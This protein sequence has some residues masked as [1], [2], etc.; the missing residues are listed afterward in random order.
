MYV[1]QNT[2]RAACCPV[3]P[4]SCLAVAR[5]GA[6]QMAQAVQQKKTVLKSVKEIPGP[7]TFPVIG[8]LPS[9]V[10]AGMC[11]YELGLFISCY[12][13]ISNRLYL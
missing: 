11:E 10:I 3:L 7:P 6:H 2:W 9:L 8:C 5:M 4:V 13:N 1:M 12:K